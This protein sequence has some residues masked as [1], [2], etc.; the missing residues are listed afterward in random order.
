LT[1]PSAGPPTLPPGLVTVRTASGLEYLDV[2]AGSAPQA[3]A[4]SR[5][6]I[7]YRCWLTDGRLIEDT[8]AAG[9]EMEVQVGQGDVI[10]GL[11]E[12]VVGMGEGARRRLIVPSD[13]AYGAEGSGTRIPPCATLICDLEVISVRG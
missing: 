6:R 11:D 8:W 13:L 9:H 10:P 5:V 7:H 3:R 1:D 4:G 2:E 12:G